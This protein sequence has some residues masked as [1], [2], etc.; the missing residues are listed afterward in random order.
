MARFVTNVSPAVTTESSSEWTVK[1]H[2]NSA[3]SHQKVAKDGPKPRIKEE[4][5][6]FYHLCVIIS[7]F[8]G[9]FHLDHI[10]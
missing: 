7:I 3:F 2:L 10:N 1:Y 4:G 8:I 6:G 9:V 5:D